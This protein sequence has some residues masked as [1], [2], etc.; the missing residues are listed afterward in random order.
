MDVR[1][2]DGTIVRNVPEGTTK[3]ELMRRLGKAQE[4]AG[5]LES[6]IAGGAQGL[7]DIPAGL[8][9]GALERPVDPLASVQLNQQGIAGPGEDVL[10][11]DRA[12]AQ[13]FE[14]SP[15]GQTLTGQI[16]RGVAS[17]APAFAVP[18]FRGLGLRGLVGAEATL[19]G[20][21]AAISPLREGESRLGAIGT[22]AAL[23]GGTAGLVRSIFGGARG[24]G[25]NAEEMIEQG[26]LLGLPI[27]PADLSPGLR[28]TQAALESVPFSGVQR[29]AMARSEAAGRKVSAL[30][31]Q[32][33]AKIR[34]LG[35]KDLEQ[36]KNMAR[37][38]TPRGRE[39]Q[40]VVRAIEESGEDLD[41]VILASGK[42][43]LFT[44]RLQA[45][46]LYAR[47]T[48]AAESAG[49]EPG[50][51]KTALRIA[52]EELERAQ[53][54]ISPEE[55]LIAGLSKI[56][57][58]IRARDV[59]T[60]DEMLASRRTINATAA[61][62]RGAREV[63]TEGSTAFER[64][65]DAIY[66]DDMPALAKR[67]PEVLSR[68]KAAN[69]YY[70]STYI[71]FRDS[72][73]A[74][75]VNKTGLGQ[76]LD[77]AR[78]PVDEAVNALLKKGRGDRN[79]LLISQMNERGK[80]AVS[81]KILQD[82]FEAATLRE[83]GVFTFSPGTFAT[84]LQRWGDDTLDALVGSERIKGLSKLMTTIARDSAPGRAPATGIRAA[85]AAGIA[86]TVGGV[87]SFPVLTSALLVGGN[88]LAR[89]LESKRAAEILVSI[90]RAQSRPEVIKLVGSLEAIAARAASGQAQ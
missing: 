27:Q 36:V 6:L 80:A 72:S 55:G 33:L 75:A 40:A 54:S 16:S 76:N 82:A 44:K 84:H 39:A 59:F 41:S 67:S 52:E 1:L 79:R 24:I 89:L 57:E 15:E 38:N 87:M 47:A 2:P 42:L 9:Q 22:G 51:M 50:Q 20:A 83:G 65:A 21:Q 10:A 12:R 7:R 70:R 18:A 37:A 71:P 23:A 90:S 29:R 74:D 35:M 28:R 56:V 32:E 66:F 73:L 88:G 68:L 69:Q 64:I 78:K 26:R 45:D 34:A 81:T 53:R 48:E 4:P 11:A 14:Q 43:E 17:S 77:S 58:N 13:Q 46:K 49:L 25:S 85:D 86:G 3:R 63:S 62:L 60:L 5:F 19:G 30:I 31:D 61:R 8:R